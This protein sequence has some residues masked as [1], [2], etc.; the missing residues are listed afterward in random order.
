[1]R[2]IRTPLILISLI[3]LLN[4]CKNINKPGT[5]VERWTEQKVNDWYKEQGW[6]V[7]ANFVP[8]SAINQ[9]EMWQGETFDTEGIERELSWA[10]KLG[11]NTM[12]VFLHHLLWEQDS[13]GFIKRID[14]Y[15]EISG[16]NN[17]KTMFVLLD[18]VWNPDPKLGK[19]QEP[20]KNLHNSGWVQSPG[21]EILTDSTQWH[22]IEGYV[23]GIITHYS[24]DSR[25]VIWDLYNEPG[26]P[27]GSSYKKLEPA[28]K[29]KHS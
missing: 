29:K 14:K 28:N 15:L 6:L 22:I 11:F 8:S 21:R 9:L 20:K 27:N 26:N 5:P 2:I 19:Q 7:G 24:N 13:T 18:D 3:V 16:K 17:I 1:M 12:R 4:S 10:N 23:K 25:V